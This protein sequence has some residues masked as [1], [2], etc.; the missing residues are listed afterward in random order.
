MASK[1]ELKLLRLALEACY[2][3]VQC[4]VAAEA[5]TSGPASA[6]FDLTESLCAQPREHWED[7]Q[8]PLSELAV[9]GLDYAQVRTPFLIWADAPCG[10]SFGEV[11]LQ[12]GP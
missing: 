10:L 5:G 7:W 1:S 3:G 12:A 11:Y 8:I 9:N 4:L 6:S 2:L